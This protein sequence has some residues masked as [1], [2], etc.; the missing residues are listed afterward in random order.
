[1]SGTPDGGSHHNAPATEA[2]LLQS[3]TSGCKPRDDWRLGTEHEKIG[4]CLDSL[5]PIPYEGARSIHRALELLVT[6]GWVLDY[7]DGNPIA[8]RRGMANI[9]LEPGGQLE[10]SGAPLATVHETCAEVRDHLRLLSHVR[11][12]LRIGFLGL[13]FQ[14]KW[15]RDEIPWMPKGRYAVMRRYMPQVGA[16]GLDMMLRTATVQVN[17]DFASETDMVRKMRVGYCLQ[18]LVTALFAASPFSDGEP[19]GYLST[20]AAA[21]LDTD[22]A[23]TGIP[24]MIFDENFGFERYMHWLLDVPMYFVIRDGKYIDCAGQSFRDFLKGK[25][26]ALPGELPTMDDW[27]LHMT[28]VYPEVRLKRYME[29]RGADAGGKPW[30]CALPALWKGLLYDQKALDKVHAMVADWTHAEVLGMRAAVPERGLKTRFRE[31]TLLQLAEDVVDIARAGL[32]HSRQLNAAGQD[33]TIH[34][35][36]VIRAV[37]NNWTQAE[38]WLE[39][40]HKDWDGRIEPIFQFA[41]L[42]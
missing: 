18:P 23:R 42:P 29:M 24:A 28:T 8:L 37:D 21:W 22:R 1:M 38:A 7:E 2:D 32:E 25:L 27:E 31:T 3:F 10:L 9:T 4:F 33:E 40:Y 36:P 35:A 17:L 13:G 30:I 6:D 19:S 11:Q 34:L 12:D 26:A 14:P 39:A 16:H 15:G 20:R 5:R 41:A